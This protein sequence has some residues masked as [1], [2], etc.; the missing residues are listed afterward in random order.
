MTAVAK[1][2]IVRGL[3]SDALQLVQS[4]M[5]EL[6][7]EDNKLLDSD[8]VQVTCQVTC[9]DLRFLLWVFN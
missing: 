3:V 8:G 2:M 4:R 1:A 5:Q 7:S 6:R 9:N